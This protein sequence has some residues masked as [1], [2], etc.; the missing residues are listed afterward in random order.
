[1]PGKTA[2]FSVPDEFGLKTAKRT[3]SSIHYSSSPNTVAHALERRRKRPRHPPQERGRREYLYQCA[4]EQFSGRRSAKR[5]DYRQK[6][7]SER[8]EAVLRLEQTERFRPV[9]FVDSIALNGTLG[10]SLKGSYT[11]L[12][13]APS[14]R[15][16]THRPPGRSPTSI[17]PASHAWQTDRS[18]NL[19]LDHAHPHRS[20][21]YAHPALNAVPDQLWD[22]QVSLS[23]SAVGADADLGQ[24]LAHTLL[25][26]PGVADIDA[27]SGLKMCSC[28]H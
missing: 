17:C 5:D 19:R 11:S 2:A 4:G 23:L 18:I 24:S 8:R 10:L 21:R 14:R 25:H 15:S 20:Q 26:P 22:E 6:L 12:A 16:L 27:R 7:Q 1:M 28:H 13:G 9:D 3:R